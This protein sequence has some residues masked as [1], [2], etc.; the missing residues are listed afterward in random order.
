MLKIIKLFIIF[1]F[2][3]IILL[4]SVLFSGIK[5]NSFS[6]GNIFVS[7]FY[8]KLN[9]KLIVDIENIEIKSKK[10]QVNNSY[11]DLKKNIKLLPKIL[12][13]FEKI[14]VERLKIDGN[15]FT[16]SLNDE[17]L[18]LDNKFVNISS[19][20]DFVS[21]Q[22]TF[23][24]Y[25]LYL[26]DIKVMLDGKVKL[27]YLNEK[28]DHFG[29][30][31][32]K[33]IKGD[34]KLNMTTKLA[35]FYLNTETFNNLNFI[36]DFASLPSIAEEW[37]YNNIKGDIK[38][39]EL[40]GKFD[41]ENFKLIEK[42]IHAK[43]IISNASINFNK[44]LHFIKTESI[45]LNFDK[46]KLGLKLNNPTY[47]GISLKGSYVNIN[48]LTDANKGEVVVNINANTKLDDNILK[49]LKQYDIDLPLFQK[50]GKT[51][52]NVLLKIPYLENKEMI[53]RGTFILKN[54]TM[55]LNSFEFKTTKAKVK[56]I[57]SLVQIVDADVTHKD[58]INANLNLDI[59]T[60]TSTAKG[61]VLIKSFLIK[62][63]KDEIVH[64]KNKKSPILVNF[65]D[66]TRIS[67]PTLT[68]DI[69]INDYIYVDITKLESIYDSSTLLKDL[70]IKAG[71]ISLK[72]KDENDISFSAFIIGLDFPLEKNNKKIDSLDIQGLISKDNIN[73]NSIDNDI[74][75]KIIKEDLFI[76]LKDLSVIVNTKE[77]NDKEVPSLNV[78]G[79]N[80]KLILDEKL[81]ELEKVNANISSKDITFTAELKNLNIP[82]RKN[83]KDVKKLSII[84]KV[85]D[86]S[87]SIRTKD[88]KLNLD[89]IGKDTLNIIVDSYD[90][91]I[92]EDKEDKKNKKEE[93]PFENFSVKAK[94]SNIIYN[95]YKFLADS[96]TVK[97]KGETKSFHL[98]YGKTDLIYRKNKKGKVSLSANNINDKFLNT[99]FNKNIIKGG[100][101][102][103]LASGDDSSL[104]G[105]IL[106][107]NNKIEEL[108]IINNLLLFIHTSP[109]LINPYLA[110]PSVLNMATKGGVNLT[111]YKIIDG[112]MN[113][114]Y[115][116]KKNLF[117]IPQLLTLGN[118]IDFDGKGVLDIN[119]L[120]LD[121]T[122]KL[123][124]FKD[125]TSIVGA[126]PVVNYVVLGDSKRVETK[127]DIFGPLDNPKIS[128]NLTKDAF[129]VPVNIAKRILT[130]P[131]KL[132]EFISEIG[133]DEKKI[134]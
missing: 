7:Q 14:N 55:L 19:K 21:K 80:L 96:F 99:I 48:N 40:Y 131:L 61:E 17:F 23:D 49:I 105:K 133:K 29:K 106:F 103:L 16:I 1:V 95:K 88:N 3:V 66:D 82:L 59:D 75:V 26:K 46:N 34:I 25:S 52:A 5:I 68:T 104:K 43:A 70:S 31:F 20:M 57:D 64:V 119:T 13:I 65:K 9:K 108:A 93:N 15:E 45:D 128:T 89:F 121:S 12:K 51:K 22:I 113:F 97:F 90:I 28:L 84:G 117:N 53:T 56:L 77:K 115:D 126:I 38:L 87:T 18:Y 71:K 132:F 94:K 58:M 125:Y 50:S 81:Y 86:D 102:M 37:M 79:E 92:E 91:Y 134:K 124:F 127:V 4:S 74:K 44:K 72:I 114:D 30:Y 100:K 109:A 54:S 35:S 120:K 42:S 67:I 41:F 8:I 27:D 32:Y 33:D 107:D 112:F 60:L 11:E 24:L 62:S 78:K 130:S 10:S 111:G 63:E 116:L 2:F 47:N 83:N 98:V 85:N 123:I 118:G 36:K 73:I 39:K 122:L 6:F 129:S 69:K 110:I 101:L 76:D